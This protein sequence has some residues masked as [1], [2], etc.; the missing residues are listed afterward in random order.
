MDKIWYTGSVS[1]FDSRCIGGEPPMF[2]AFTRAMRRDNT[3]LA[4]KQ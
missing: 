1:F 3:S 2:S 4:I